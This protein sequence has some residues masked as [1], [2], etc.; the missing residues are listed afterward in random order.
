MG[1][2]L[3]SCISLN[4]FYSIGFHGFPRISSA[5]LSFLSHRIAIGSIEFLSRLA[6]LIMNTVGRPIIVS[7]HPGVRPCNGFLNTRTGSIP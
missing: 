3:S 6:I 7:T 4:D 5:Y 2:N 1:L